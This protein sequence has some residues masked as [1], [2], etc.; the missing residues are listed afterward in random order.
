MHT[1]SRFNR[2]HGRRR[3]FTVKKVRGEL[4]CK[5]IWYNIWHDPSTAAAA[6]FAATAAAATATIAKQRL[7]LHRGNNLYSTITTMTTATTT[8]PAATTATTSTTAAATTTST[9]P[10]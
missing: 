6:A 5:D 8:A 3:S 2:A 1:T 9:K 7:E 10:P 4:C